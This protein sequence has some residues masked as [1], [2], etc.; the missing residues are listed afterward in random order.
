MDGIIIFD[1]GGGSFG[2]MTDL[3]SSFDLRTGIFTTSERFVRAA[4]L[5]VVAHIALPDLQDVSNERHGDSGPLAVPDQGHWLLLNGRFPDAASDGA[6]ELGN[7]ECIETSE[8]LIIR[9]ASLSSKHLLH[10]CEHGELPSDVVMTTVSGDDGLVHPWDV[11]TTAPKRIESDFNLMRNDGFTSIASLPVDVYL[12]GERNRFAIHPTAQLGPG[13]VIDTR[14]GMVV[15]DEHVVIDPGAV[16]VGPCCIGAHTRIAP[17][18]HVKANT[19]VGPHC[20]LGGEIG[21]SVFQGFANKSHHGH[22]GDSWVGEWA[23]LGA[24]TV[25]SNLLNTYGEVSLRL[26]PNGPRIR[27]G[28]NFLGAIIGDHVKT[29]IGTRIMTGSVLGTGAMVACSEPPPGCTPRFAW[30]TDAAEGTRHYQIGKF[31]DVARAVMSRRE[32]VPGEAYSARLTA[33]REGME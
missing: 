16:L 21:S 2:P 29:A 33:L 30:L 22:L 15:V 11:L 1:D 19:V 18:T 13:V 31:L 20:R 23:N 26:E 6:I 24:G 10:W 27:S 5:P 7:A 28:R 3:R 8:G 14:E 17:H 9:R 4:R 12:R 25:N 32:C